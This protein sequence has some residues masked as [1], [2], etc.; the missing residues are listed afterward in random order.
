MTT[1]SPSPL[2]LQIANALQVR[3]VVLRNMA[4]AAD[5]EEIATFLD[6]LLRPATHELCH[7]AHLAT[8]GPVSAAEFCGGCE[9]FQRELYGKSPITQLRRGAGFALQTALEYAHLIEE[10]DPD[11]VACIRKA[12]ER[13]TE[14]D[15]AAVKDG[16]APPI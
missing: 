16:S 1:P 15:E 12:F 8:T 4:V 9:R 10:V 13:L 14:V 11:A 5:T 3:F 6:T 7:D 2:A